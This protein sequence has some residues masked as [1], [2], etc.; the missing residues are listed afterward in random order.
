[1]RTKLLNNK[2]Q[3]TPLYEEYIS[4]FKQKQKYGIKQNAKTAPTTT[5]VCMDVCMCTSRMTNMK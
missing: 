1:M 4:F 3:T 2:Q 5:C